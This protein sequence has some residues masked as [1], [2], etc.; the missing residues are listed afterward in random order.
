VHL[1]CVRFQARHFGNKENNEYSF[2]IYWLPA[3]CQ[4]LSH[5][6]WYQTRQI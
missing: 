6:T 4:S 3:V 5:G 2:I 1:L